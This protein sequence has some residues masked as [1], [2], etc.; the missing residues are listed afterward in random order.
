M[1][2]IQ[3]SAVQEVYALVADWARRNDK[4]LRDQL[5]KLGV[6]VSEELFQAISSKTYELAAAE[7]GMDLSFLTYGRFRDMGVGRGSRDEARDLSIGGIIHKVESQ[8]TNGRLIRRERGAGGRFKK[9]KEQ[10]KGRK[11]A[12]WYSR[13]FYGRLTAL[14]GAISGK[15]VEQAIRAVQAAGE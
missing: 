11:P 2:T 15:T 13:A 10:P 6:G 8:D 7:V 12:K 4:I 14:Q 1:S 9:G 3:D 5:K